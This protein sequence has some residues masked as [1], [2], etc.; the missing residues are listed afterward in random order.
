[1]ATAVDI[2]PFEPHPLLRGGHLQTIAGR[3]LPSPKVRLRSTYH[4]IGLEDGD[5]LSVLESVPAGWVRGG[6]TAL[7]VHG[8]AG[9]A[10][11]PYVVRVAARLTGIGVRV[12]RMN[13]RGAGSGFGLARGIYH[14]GRTE[15]LRAVA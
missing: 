2:P 5:W 8:L 7:L 13:L 10:R 6:P 9:C 3:Y 12:V 14:S 15:D 11:S 4:E 1:M